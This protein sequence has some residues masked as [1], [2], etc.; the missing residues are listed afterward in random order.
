VA[1]VQSS[2]PGAPRGASASPSD[3]LGP[4]EPVAGSPRQS[5]ALG[6]LV[7]SLDFERALATR[8]RASTAH[9]ALHH[10]AGLPAVRASASSRLA[11]RQLSTTGEQT[12]PQPVEDFSPA[13]SPTG[14][15]W[16]GAVVP[17]RHAKRA[18]TRSLIKRQIYAVTMR[19]QDRLAPGLWVVRL[20][21]PFDRAQFKS[22]ASA[23]LRHAVRSELEA[24]L[25]AA[26]RR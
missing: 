10:V 16:V 17:K 25:A 6:R 2:T 26:A 4:G 23:A 9:F 13:V 12:S 11:Q 22:A 15:A 18:V 21:A 24:A 5:R 8:S 14:P 3:P 20:R 7:A 1:G 19:Q